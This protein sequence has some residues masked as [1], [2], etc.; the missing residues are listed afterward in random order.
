M[1]RSGCRGYK[2]IY[3]ITLLWASC[4]FVEMLKKRR[5]FQGHEPKHT[6]DAD[7]HIHKAMKTIRQFKLDYV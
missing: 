3:Q 5:N 4:E 1:C 2:I 7:G 6:Y